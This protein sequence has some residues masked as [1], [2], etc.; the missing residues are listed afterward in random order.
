VPLEKSASDAARERNVEREIAAGTPP[1]QAV[2]IAYAT[3]RDVLRAHAN[4][5]SQRGK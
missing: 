2:A 4:R 3:Q 1:T 5:G